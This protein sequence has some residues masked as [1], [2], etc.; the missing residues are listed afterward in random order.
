MYEATPCGDPRGNG[1]GRRRSSA[2]MGQ[3]GAAWGRR[4][5][6]LLISKPCDLAATP[7]P[8]SA[9]G[10]GRAD[11]VGRTPDPSLRCRG[12]GV[13]ADDRLGHR[14][15]HR[16]GQTCRGHGPPLGHSPMKTSS[17]STRGK[18]SGGWRKAGAGR[19]ARRYLSISKRDSKIVYGYP[20][21]RQPPRHPS[22]DLYA[23][24]HSTRQPLRGTLAQAGASQSPYQ[25]NTYA[26]NA[27]CAN[28]NRSGLLGEVQVCWA[29]PAG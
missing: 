21:T 13:T 16:T 5:Y 22:A 17:V 6:S 4:A 11:G 20:T 8:K 15:G 26:R 28:V 29:G 23:R 7:H 27:R 2:A 18:A 19:S 10:A 25:S 3:K 12:Q 9:R 1:G 24:P 14:S